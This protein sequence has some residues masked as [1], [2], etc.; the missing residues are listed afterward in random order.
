M[1]F[2]LQADAICREEHQSAIDAVHCFNGLGGIKFGGGGLKSFLKHHESIY[3]L[4]KKENI[5]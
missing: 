5:D 2:T 4:K 1:L 3:K